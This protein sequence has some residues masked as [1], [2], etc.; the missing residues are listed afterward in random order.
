[1]LLKD[2]NDTM[3]WIARIFVGVL[4]IFSGLIKLNDPLGFSY[5]LEEY[6]EVFHIVALN[7]LAIYISIF[8]CA[9]EVI[10]GVFL[11]AGIS[12]KKVSWGLLILV[13]FFTFLTFYSAAFDVVKS[14]GCFGDAIPLT[15][16]ES[17]TKDLI[18]LAF[19]IYIFI[20]RSRIYPLTK[21]KSQKTTLSSVTIGFSLL[22]GIYTYTF[23][24]IIDFL[25]YK[26]GLSII[27]GMKIPENAEQN[28]YEIIY[29]LTHKKTGE[30]KKITD[31][32]YLR[33]KIYE[34]ENW[35]LTS[36][37]D[38]KLIKEGFQPRIKDLN[39]Y[40]SQ[41]VNYTNEIIENP[42]Y[43]LI[44]VGW[45]LD[46]SSQ[47]AAKAINALA[48]N[49]VQNYNTRTVWLTTNSAESAEKFAA[50]LNLVLEIFY[51]DAVPLKSMV[52]SNPGLILMKNGVVIQKWSA[53]ALPT[54]KE[55]ES[56]YLSHN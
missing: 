39:I 27:E 13:L 17:F 35:D 31:K 37:S 19:I 47:N 36:S 7:P 22:L 2:K 48:I 6:F 43:N 38:P 40:D 50:D 46:N 20:N 3:L 51:A 33:T 23:L 41:G 11:L 56:N 25:P 30:V 28:E 49:T 14:C 52:R 55:L 5:K 12:M 29:T 45:K 21:N 42:Y 16:W 54:Y 9:L 18:L 34:D 26:E 15:P 32:E 4:F 24:P 8:L 1:M 53:A 10:L 44:A